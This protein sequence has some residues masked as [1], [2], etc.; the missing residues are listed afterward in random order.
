MALGQVTRSLLRG[1]RGRYPGAAEADL[2]KYLIVQFEIAAAN[3]KKKDEELVSMAEV[4]LNAAADRGEE[5]AT[6]LRDNVLINV[7]KPIVEKAKAIGADAASAVAVQ[8]GYGLEE[9]TALV[10]KLAER[11][12]ASAEGDDIE[13]DDIEGD[14]IEGDDDADEFDA[15]DADQALASV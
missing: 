12:T 3:P 4:E 13:G 2:Q 6:N 1:Y 5:W 14:K 10:E 15:D 9:A 11:G 7:V 8:A